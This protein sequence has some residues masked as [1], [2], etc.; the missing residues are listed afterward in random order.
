M[1]VKNICDCHYPPGGRVECEPRQMALCVVINNQVRRECID[2]PPL[3]TPTEAANWA[4]GVIYNDPSRRNN[5]KITRKDI[6]ILLSGTYITPNGAMVNFA[7]P[8]NI[9]SLIIMY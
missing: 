2:P 6:D 4:L 1:P 7:I 9:K 3:E 8:T 5:A